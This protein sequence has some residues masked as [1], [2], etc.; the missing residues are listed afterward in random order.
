MIFEVGQLVA[1][2]RGLG[3]AQ[4]GCDFGKFAPVVHAPRHQHGA[5][6]KRIAFEHGGCDG[7]AHDE[8]LQKTGCRD[9]PATPGNGPACVKRGQAPLR[10]RFLRLPVKPLRRLDGV[11]FTVRNESWLKV[12]C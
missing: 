7:V 9:G 4:Q 5:A 10:E 2:G 3:V 8:E 12:P 11:H 6:E 1:A